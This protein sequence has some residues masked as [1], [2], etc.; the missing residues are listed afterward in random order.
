MGLNSANKIETNK[1]ELEISVDKDKFA[2]AV[3]KAFKK[4]AKR[5]N[6]PGFRRGKAPRSVIEKLYGEGIFY[7]DAV[8]S[9]YPQAYEEAVK[10]AGIEPVDRAD[11]EVVDISKEKGVTFKAKVTV[12]PDVEL[13][14]YKGLKAVKKVYTVS[15]DEVNHELE[16][17]RERNAR[18]I[19]VEDRA[20]Q[21]GDIAV[22]DYEG[23]L[24][25]KPFKGGKAEKQELELGS[26]TFIPGFEDQIIGHKIGENFEINVTFP[27]NY[28]SKELAGK[29][30]V[31]KIVLHELKVRELP[32][33]DDEFAKDVS[34]F[35]TLD[36][37][38]ADIKKRIQE[39]KDKRSE[40]E[41]E[42]ALV[43]QIIGSMKAE[44]PEVMF[45]R[46][47]DNMVNDFNYRLQMQGM[48]LK[49]YLH[50]AGMEMDEFRKTF[51]E[52]A[53]RQVKMRLALEKI[54]ANEKFEVTDE[55]LDAE[56]KKLAGQYG[57]DAEKIKNIINADDLKKDI[58]VNKAIDFVRD[59]AVITEEAATE[60]THKHDDSES[61]D[62]KD[63]KVTKASKDSKAKTEKK[64]TRKT[65]KDSSDKE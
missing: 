22:I 62:K 37:Y 55:D 19:T 5:I 45:E 64:T 4:N 59:N 11:I 60:E 61:K 36:E 18:I 26:G 3:D 34:E 57:I 14:E 23:F 48:N 32:E 6:V 63:S 65:K 27:E 56:Y 17:V 15:D 10:E 9:L 50:Y 1:Y 20:A 43:E 24:D 25:G 13:G 2:E 51:R 49:T 31:F 33:L 46:A 16:H 39:A 40:T 44:I 35:D 30:A 21:K 54:V 29:P 42:D 52:Q 47:I 8:N 28:H 7:E 38:K 53:E 58:A 12:K 41:V